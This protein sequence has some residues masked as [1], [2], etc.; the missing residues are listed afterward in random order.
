MVL[1]RADFVLW[2]RGNLRRHVLVRVRLREVD[3][4][5]DAHRAQIERNRLTI[6]RRMRAASRKVDILSVHLAQEQLRKEEIDIV[7]GGIQYVSQIGWLP[8]YIV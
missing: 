7:N 8:H 4:A 5:L 3:L 6:L 1:A 2:R